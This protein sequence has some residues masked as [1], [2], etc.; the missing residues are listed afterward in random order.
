ALKEVP[1]LHGPLVVLDAPS[2]LGLMPP[3]RGRVPGVHKLPA[4]LRAA[5]LV[6]GLR[7]ADAGGVP[8]PAYSA[9][10]DPDTGIRNAYALRAYSLELAKQV[11]KLVEAGAFP[12]VLGGDCSIL[13][14]NLLALRRLGRYGLFFI[15]GHT[16]LQTP[17]TSPTGGA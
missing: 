7:A 11:G 15:D 5:G 6:A 17:R 9:A 2:N 8:A 4:A 12:V 13:L 10:I 14:G 1:N 3:A 16:D